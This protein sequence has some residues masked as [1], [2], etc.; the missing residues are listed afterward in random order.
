M[1]S[2]QLRQSLRLPADGDYPGPSPPLSYPY[3]QKA[4]KLTAIAFSWNE[5]FMQRIGCTSGLCGFV[6]RYQTHGG[7]VTENDRRVN[8][9]YLSQI[10]PCP[11]G[12]ADPL[13][14][15]TCGGKTL[16]ELECLHLELRHCR[17]QLL[18][19]IYQHKTFR[20]Q[21][22]QKLS[23]TGIE[24]REIE[25]HASEALPPLQSLSICPEP[26]AHSL[27][28][29]TQIPRPRDL[30]GLCPPVKQSFAGGTNAQPLDLSQRTLG[31]WIKPA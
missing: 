1:L 22:V 12:G 23:R 10:I 29:G 26:L 20:R 27:M 15:F 19:V 4:S 18:Q 24:V 16:S 11:I 21:I 13:G 28:T 7:R 25:L 30:G 14:Q 17:F 2:P 3:V 9:P 5:G 8:F 31:A 6:V